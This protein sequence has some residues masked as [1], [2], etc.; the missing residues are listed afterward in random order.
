MKMS[1]SRYLCRIKQAINMTQTVPF[2]QVVSRG[3]GIDVHKKMVVATIRGEGLRTQTREFNT[4]T[5]SLTELRDWLLANGITHVAMES[6]GVYWKPVYHVLEPGGLKVWIVNARHIKY[7]P[8][9]KTDRKY[10]AWICKLLLAGLL[11]PGYIPPKEQRALRDLTR[12]RVRLIQHVA[13][14]KNRTIRILEDCN[15]KL[16]GVLTS[17]SG[18]TATKLIDKLC[19]GEVITMSDINELYHKKIQ[20]SKEELYEA[21]QGC[22]EEHHVY[23]SGTIRRDMEQTEV[24]IA[25]LSKRIKNL[26][27]GYANVLE[28]LREIP[29]L[30]TKTVEDLVAETG[31]DMSVFP[32]EQHLA[33]WAGM[34]PG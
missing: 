19:D 24:L 31:L 13:S 4:F 2:E 20:A 15:I 33:S 8:G 32:S 25:D 14:E 23:L 26:L 10:S 22:V 29:G 12:Y 30:S 9:H 7:V 21:C 3:C 16:S 28:L 11:K 34:C 17:T 27:S 1:G 5:S 18:V 6:T